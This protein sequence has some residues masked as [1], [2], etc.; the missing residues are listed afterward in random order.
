[1]LGR[2]YTTA[3]VSTGYAGDLMQ[4]VARPHNVACVDRPLPYRPIAESKGRAKAAVDYK[5][6]EA[7]E[8]YDSRNAGSDY[9][10]AEGKARGKDLYRS[11]FESKEGGAESKESKSTRRHAGAK[12]EGAKG[13][14]AEDKAQSKEVSRANG[15]S[16]LLRALN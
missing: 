3:P 8:S 4:S 11:A 9:Q 13:E 7:K 10:R 16:A 2:S 1:V 5:H 15:K 12:S 6:S 14:Y